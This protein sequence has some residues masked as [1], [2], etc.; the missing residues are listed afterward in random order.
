MKT[1]VKHHLHLCVCE[2]EIIRIEYFKFRSEI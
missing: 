1:R 2:M